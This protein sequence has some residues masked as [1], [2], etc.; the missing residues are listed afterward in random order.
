MDAFQYDK[1]AFNGEHDAIRTINIKPGYNYDLVSCRVQ[2]VRLSEKPRY[3]ALSY[4][5][6]N[7]TPNRAIICNDKPFRITTNLDL[8][9]RRLR[10]ETEERILWAD[11]ICINQQD[12]DERNQQVRLMRQ[13]YENAERVVVW[14]GE[15]TNHSDLG[16]ALVP[17]LIEADKKRNESGDTRDISELKTAGLRDIYGLPMRNHD[18]WKGFFGILNR[19]WFERGWVIQE[20]AVGTS[21]MVY[22]GRA[23]VSFKDFMAALI[24]SHDIGLASEYMN[25]NYGRLFLM[26]LTRQAVQSEIQQDLLCLLF[27]HRLALTTDPRDKVFALCGLAADNGQDRLAIIPDYRQPVD[28]LYRVVAVKMMTRN[29]NLDI[30]SVPIDRESHSRP[31]WVPDLSK[32]VMTSS[33]LGI[34]HNIRED[35]PYRASLATECSPTFSNDGLLLGLS[36]SLFD[37]ICQM[38]ETQPLE[39]GDNDAFRPIGGLRDAFE[40]RKRYMNWRSIAGLLTK[41]RYVTGESLEDAYWQTLIAGYNPSAGQ[42]ADKDRIKAHYMAWKRHSFK[43]AYLRLLPSPL[44]EWILAF[45]LCASFLKAVVR[46]LICLPFVSAPHEFKSMMGN[47]ASRR[48]VRTQRGYLGLAGDAVRVGDAIV[49]CKGGKLPLVVRGEYRSSGQL[50]LVSDCYVHGI[51]NGE[52]FDEAKCK[53]LWFC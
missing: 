15:D 43:Y 47:A 23:A 40:E 2:H 11:A 1:I 19:A 3:E 36:G 29:K 7:P 39:M 14:L 42:L 33:L 21:I 31:S 48:L 27:R 6:G 35:S 5:W 22:C 38:G 49:L 32:P 46:F 25:E 13:I 34:E 52:A 30:L 24:F 18:A 8:A 44:F 26:G 37:V 10:S 17:K 45:T 9:L 53:Q 51:M 20:V 28:E 12:I 41:R 4:C 16:M 50:R